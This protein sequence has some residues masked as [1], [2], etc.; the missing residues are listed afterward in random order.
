M[1]RPRDTLSHMEHPL[2]KRIENAIGERSIEAA[3]KEWQVPYYVLRDVLARHTRIPR[4]PEH[5][6]AIADGA[7]MTT[8]FFLEL[9]YSQKT[10]AATT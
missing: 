1:G 10:V 9:A 6:K 4:R 8:S 5:T 7:G 3:A 2:T